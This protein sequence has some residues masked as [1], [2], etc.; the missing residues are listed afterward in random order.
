[1]FM[2]AKELSSNLRSK[3]ETGLAPRTSL[4]LTPRRFN[5]PP[6]A[7]QPQLAPGRCDSEVGYGPYDRNTASPPNLVRGLRPSLRGAP[8]SRLSTNSGGNMG[9]LSRLIFYHL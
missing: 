7:G 4:V 9:E 5:P 6:T 2:K 1:M 8:P 3:T